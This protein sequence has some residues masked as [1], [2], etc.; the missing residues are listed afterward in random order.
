LWQI[1]AL[2]E[3]RQ[4]Q[5]DRSFD[6]VWHLTWANAWY[7]SLAAVAGRPFVY[8]PV[9]GCV[10]TVWHLLPHLGW[11]GA[12][13][14]TGRAIVH[15]TARHL[16]PLARLS[17]RRADLVLAQNP[18][19]RDWL[20]RRHRRKTILF[21][22]AVIQDEII[23]A[24]TPTAPAGV[25]SALYAGRLE[26]FKGV[27]LCLYAITELPDWRL[28]VCGSGKDEQRL[29]RLA[30]RLGVSDRV[31]WLGW[32]PRDELLG[33]MAEAD[34]FM[35]PSLH[36]EAGAAVA[37]ARAMGLPVI[38]LARGGPP[39]LAGPA[40]TSVSYAG[41]P[42][43]IARRLAD[44]ALAIVEHPRRDDSDADTIDALSLDHQTEL[45]RDVVASSVAGSRHNA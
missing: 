23:R 30:D 43:A 7:G 36:E 37:E 14:E 15:K 2:Q 35:F 19:T 41:G 39:L 11:N 21:P 4:L 17:W 40:G 3:A 9:G 5:R 6:V 33:K 34:V 38:C 24:V 1:A 20:P 28:V 31:D 42:R 12:V 16:N 8:G 22:N 29:R 27:F 44:A 13:Y 25:R 45:L 26:P 32:L 18:E 10:G